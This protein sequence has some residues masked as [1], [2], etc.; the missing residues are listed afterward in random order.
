MQKQMIPWLWVRLV[1]LLIFFVFVLTQQMPIVALIALILFVLTA[2]Q[3][4][5]AYRA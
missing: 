4:R 1:G 2:I 3:L 5:S